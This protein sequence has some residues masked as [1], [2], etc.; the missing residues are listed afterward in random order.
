M[1]GSVTV[2]NGVDISGIDNGGG[3]A[4][5]FVCDPQ[6]ASLIHQLWQDPVI[7]KPQDNEPQQ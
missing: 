7:P 3:T 2:V 1:L 4:G 6:I 5:G